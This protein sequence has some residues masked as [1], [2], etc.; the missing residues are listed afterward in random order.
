LVTVQERLASETD[1]LKKVDLHQSKIEI[2]DLLGSTEGDIDITKLEVA[3]AEV[4]SSY[5]DR[6]GISYAAWRSVGV[7]ADVLK[8]AGVARTRRG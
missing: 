6:K 2:E 1:T 4:A 7:P 5:S 8:K 3:F